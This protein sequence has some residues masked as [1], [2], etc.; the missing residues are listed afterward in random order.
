MC[1]KRRELPKQAKSTKDKTR[2]FSTFLEYLRQLLIII[3]LKSAS[4]LPIEW[5]ENTLSYPKTT[6]GQY[7]FFQHS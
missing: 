5:Q 1:I 7:K 2:R 4:I 6:D 3:K